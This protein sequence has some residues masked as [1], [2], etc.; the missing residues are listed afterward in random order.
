MGRDRGLQDVARRTSD[1]A[2]GPHVYQRGNV[3]WAYLGDGRRVS[4][5]TTDAAEAE[6]RFG[7]HLAAGRTRPARTAAPKEL[8]LAE[9]AGKYT[10]TNAMNDPLDETQGAT[11]LY[12]AGVHARCASPPMYLV[13][14]RWWTPRWY[15]S[16]PLAC[17]APEGPACCEGRATLCGR[18]V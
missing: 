1:R 16:G 15:M 13:R 7:E 3:W 14:C 17:R 12:T 5:R 11:S 6:R 4:L 10:E 2:D 18:R 8:S 9:L